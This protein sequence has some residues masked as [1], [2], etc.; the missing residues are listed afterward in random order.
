MESGQDR[1]TLRNILQSVVEEP[2]SQSADE[3][4]EGVLTLSQTSGRSFV[5]IVELAV[6]ETA[7]ETAA[8]DGVLA[9]C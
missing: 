3:T 4:V 9:S 7:S 6:P 2:P 5:Q 1:K 8:V